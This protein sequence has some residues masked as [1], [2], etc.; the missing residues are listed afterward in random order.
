MVRG[1]GDV[2]VLIIRTDV[3]HADFSHTPEFSKDFPPAANPKSAFEQHAEGVY[4]TLQYQYGTD[5]VSR[6]DKAIEIEGDSLPRGADVVPCLQ[7]RKFWEDYPG[8]YMRGITFW[9]GEGEHVIN[10]PERHRI[11]GSQYHS[12]TSEK[13]K[14]TIRLF[15]NLRNDLV[16]K[17]RI[18]KV[19]A[20]S[21]FIECL[22]S[23]VPVELIRTDDVSERSEEI[24]SY[25]DSKSEEELSHFT[26]QHGLRELFG[27][28]TVQWDLQDAQLFIR[29]ADIL[30]HE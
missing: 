18:E 8:N 27:P 25:L 1:S 6:G 29:E 15:K 14:P 30:L 24:I 9:T 2:D 10:F 4:R 13:Y 23:N 26:T 21:Y 3:Y 19:Q 12:I 20:P 5:N 7:H 28:R 17:D 11:Q 22:L 16:E